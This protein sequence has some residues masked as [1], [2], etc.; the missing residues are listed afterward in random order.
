VARVVWYVSSTR[1][2]IGQGSNPF[3]SE[4]TPKDGGRWESGG[5]IEAAS[6]VNTRN[7]GVAQ[8]QSN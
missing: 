4:R 2:T 5:K 6:L 7:A 8:R 3:A 1:S